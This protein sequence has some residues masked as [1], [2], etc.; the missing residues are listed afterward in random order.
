MW[1]ACETSQAWD[2]RATFRASGKKS[3]LLFKRYLKDCRY[4]HSTFFG[5]E[6][7]R[8]L[9]DRSWI[10]LAHEF[11]GGDKPGEAVGFGVGDDEAV[12]GIAGP[13]L[14]ESGA[15]DGRKGKIAEAEVGFVADLL[16]QIPGEKLRFSEL[17]EVFEFEKCHG[18]DQQLR[19]VK[20]ASCFGTQAIDF[21]R[22]KPK[23]DVSVKIGNQ[24]PAQS[25]S[26][27]FSISASHS[28]L[29]AG[30]FISKFG[31]TITSI[32]R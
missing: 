20:K 3:G 29:K 12:E 2:A 25:F 5:K 15:G 8:P 10:V 7:S 27:S 31:S 23:D 22:R 11:V 21:A 18:G 17:S 13:L 1:Q 24:R 14:V 28:A 19:P 9:P 4:G 26:H 30:S 6:P 32:D 16:Q